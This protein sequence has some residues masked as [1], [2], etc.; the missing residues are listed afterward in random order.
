M[1]IV[2]IKSDSNCQVYTVLVTR[3]LIPMAVTFTDGKQQLDY[4]CPVS[5]SAFYRPVSINH[6]WDLNR[7]IY[8]KILAVFVGAA[9]PFIIFTWAAL[10]SVLNTLQLMQ[11]GN[12]IKNSNKTKE[13]TS[14]Q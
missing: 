13:T 3:E 7:K 2:F 6:R 12:K 4:E 10:F 14:N 9:T 1:Q 8:V 5:L 11:G